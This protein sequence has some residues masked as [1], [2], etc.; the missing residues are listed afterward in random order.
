[1]PPCGSTYLP[2]LGTVGPSHLQSVLPNLPVRGGQ[3][4]QHL[5]DALQEAEKVPSLSIGTHRSHLGRLGPGRSL[6]R[7]ARGAPTGPALAQAAREHAP[8]LPG[9][10]SLTS[11]L[12][13]ERTLP[14][15]VGHE[16]GREGVRLNVKRS[17]IRLWL[18][19][20]KNSEKSSV[21]R[22]LKSPFLVKSHR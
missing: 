13:G 14:C 8:F 17:Q 2:G 22:R 10:Y 6:G 1:M 21:Q 20:R 16:Q 11:Y 3:P 5:Q 15:T 18:S 12:K 19:H 9:V 4:T 7:R